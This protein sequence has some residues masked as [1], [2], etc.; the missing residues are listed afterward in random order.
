MPQ[1]GAVLQQLLNQHNKGIECRITGVTCVC[2]LTGVDNF[3]NLN[4]LIATPE[5]SD[6]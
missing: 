1:S 4:H 5:R 3:P 2:L 6:Y